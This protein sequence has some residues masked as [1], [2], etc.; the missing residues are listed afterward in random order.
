MFC[1]LS[2][3][4]LL[5]K[6]IFKNCA[7]IFMY[8]GQEPVIIMVLLRIPLIFTFHTVTSHYVRLPLCTDL[9]SAGKRKKSSKLKMLKMTFNSCVFENYIFAQSLKWNCLLLYGKVMYHLVF[10]VEHSNPHQIR[11]NWKTEL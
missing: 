3:C 7:C 6:Y 2:V 8:D 10:E 5:F 11:L 1:L 9:Y 4:L